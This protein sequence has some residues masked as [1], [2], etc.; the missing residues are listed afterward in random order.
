VLGT[1]G[2]GLSESRPAL[3]DHFE[4]SGPWI[5]HAA[6][7]LLEGEGELPPG[8]AA[9]AAAEWGLALDKADPATW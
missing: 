2:Y 4:V 1:D 9:A 7:A 6:L 3:R 8:S 5:A